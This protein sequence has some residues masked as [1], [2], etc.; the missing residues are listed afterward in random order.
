MDIEQQIKEA[1][2]KIKTGNDHEKA[3]A[4]IRTELHRIEWLTH[5]QSI[6]SQQAEEIKRLISLLERMDDCGTTGEDARDMH[7]YVNEAL[8]GSADKWNTS[9]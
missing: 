7:M 3:N 1:L 9:C 2:E 6:I 8:R 5:Q 4:F